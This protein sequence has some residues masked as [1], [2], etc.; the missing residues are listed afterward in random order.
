MTLFGRPFVTLL[1]AVF[2]IG[3]FLSACGD[4]ESI[5]SGMLGKRSWVDLVAD[6]QKAQSAG[7]LPEAEKLF[8]EALAKAEAKHGMDAPETGTCVGYLAELYRYQQEY[9]KADKEYK[10]WL[11]I[12]ENYDSTGEQI[13]NIRKNYKEVRKKIKQYNLLKDEDKDK[14]KFDDKSESSE[15]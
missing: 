2:L 9:L 6:A 12:M 8:Q 3:F 4:V 7:N 1:S 14:D 5:H 11:K 13:K 10:R 15:D